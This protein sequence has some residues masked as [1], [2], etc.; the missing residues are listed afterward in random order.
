MFLT[1]VC[2]LFLC[3]CFLFGAAAP[4][5]DLPCALCAKCASL[6]QDAWFTLCILKSAAVAKIRGGMA[7]VLIAA[8]NACWDSQ[9]HEFRWAG[10][11]LRL[12]SGQEVHVWAEL[13]GVIAD[14]EALHSMYA[15]KGHAGWRPC[16]LCENVYLG[17][18][19]REPREGD[20]PHTCTR[21]NDLRKH[22][23]ASHEDLAQR[24]QAAAGGPAALLQ[25]LETDMGWNYAPMSVLWSAQ[26][27]EIATPSTS[28]IYDFMHIYFVGG[29]F[30]VQVGHLL[31]HLKTHNI[32]TDMLHEFVQLFTWPKAAAQSGGQDVFSRKR[33]A[34]SWKDWSLKCTASEALSIGPVLLCYI[35]PLMTN[36][37]VDLKKHATCFYLL[38]TVIKFLMASTRPG[39]AS[40]AGRT[41]APDTLR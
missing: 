22:T 2:L 30:N 6:T 13:G 28:V 38:M 25:E 27:R 36:T 39:A 24:L 12:V 33:V 3:F 37:S 23:R 20:V 9:G 32:K 34:A 8:L 7:Q 11:Q 29:I 35:F 31:H 21:H 19:S 10:T 41:A 14:E 5:R 1:F 15:N 16:M 40:H 4:L 18:L 26:W 17:R